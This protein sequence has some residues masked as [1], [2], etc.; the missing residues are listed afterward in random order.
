M[1]GLATAYHLV[2]DG[3]R[4]TLIDRADAGRATAAGAGILSGGAAM[5]Y[6]GPRYE[7]AARSFAYYPSLIESLAADDA[8]ETGFARAPM[9]LV[10]VDEADETLFEQRQAVILGRQTPAGAPASDDLREITPGEARRYFPA[11]AAVRRVIL[12]RNAARVDGR[13]LAQALRRGGERR[14]L[15]VRHG[16]IT[17]VTVERGRALGVVLDEEVVHA[18]GVVLAAGAWSA[19]LADPLGISLRVAPQR[20]QIAHLRLAGQPT[21][22]WAIVNGFRGHYI[23]TWPDGRVVAGATRETDSGFAPVVTAAGV[24]EVL[25]EAL[26]LAPGI[27]GAELQE[28]RV[29]LRP[30]SADDSPVLGRAPGIENLYLATGHGANGLQLGPFSGKL[31]ADLALGRPPAMNL[32]PFGAS[33][34]RR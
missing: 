20:G 9:L 2:R 32:E 24:R 12:Y 19:A 16:S 27:A 18:S 34:V 11:L 22:D 30:L 15:T 5:P 21:G 25:S 23:V 33:R 29:G 3:A 14:G 1:L 31:I 7:L 4:V 26:R 28:M 6:E 10:A 17:R 13:L 8:G